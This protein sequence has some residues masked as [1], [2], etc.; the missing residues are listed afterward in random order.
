[1]TE[2]QIERKVERMIDSLDRQFLQGLFSREVY[3]ERYAEIDA[4]AK[5]ESRRAYSNTLQAQ[6]GIFSPTK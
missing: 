3:E 1:M 4:W 6:A 2:D 5:A